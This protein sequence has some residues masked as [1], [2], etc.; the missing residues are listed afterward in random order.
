M[1]MLNDLDRFHLVM[2]VI[3]RVPGLGGAGSAHPPGHGGRTAAR[4]RLHARARRRRSG[5][6]RLGLAARGVS[7]TLVVNAGSTSLK[8]SIVDEDGASRRIDSF[9]QAPDDVDAVA[10]RV[11]HGGM[12]FS[13]PVVI[14]SGVRA[15]LDG[16]GGA[17][18]APQQAGAG[19]DRA[20][21][22]A[23]C[24]DCRRS[25]CS[26]PLSI[27]RSRTRR[28]PT[29][30]R[31]GG[32]K[33]GASAVT[34]ST[35]S[36]CS[37]PPSRCGAAARR[38]PS[39]RRLLGHRGARRPLGGH[40]DGLQPARRRADG[41][42][43]GLDRRR[44]RAPPAAHEEAV[45][46]GDRA[47][48]RV[49]VR[50]ARALRRDG[51][52]RGARSVGLRRGNARARRLRASRR[53]RRRRRWRRL[54]AGSTRW[55]SRPGS[56]R[57]RRA[58]AATSASGSASSASSST[59]RRMRPLSPDVDVNVAGAACARRGAARARGCGRGARCAGAARL[60]P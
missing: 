44:D 36:R 57:A 1:V 23:S 35:A 40:D 34:G 19:G 18:A 47:R 12:R 2:D 6:S 55:S 24:R 28:R 27:A 43:L 38:L 21:R 58:S 8:L 45:A 59:W 52:G 15:A 5:H 37:G 49:R 60:R 11:V 41:D 14:D 42:A 31:L 51:A 9:E 25:P 46:R 16:A 20:R 29:R 48:A 50:L 7:R 26:T 56:A 32:A 39:R 53:R 13:D 22:W 3:D 30:C 4:A 33:N 54:S 10:H 17:R